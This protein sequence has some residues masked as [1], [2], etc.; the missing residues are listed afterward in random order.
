MRS[1]HHLCRLSAFIVF[2]F[3]T[4]DTSNVFDTSNNSG[5]HITSGLERHI[6]GL[7]TA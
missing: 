1:I 2:Y 3:C 6:I 7:S 5:F 4:D